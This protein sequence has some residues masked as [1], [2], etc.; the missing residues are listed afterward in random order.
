[1]QDLKMLIKINSLYVPCQL[2]SLLIFFKWKQ[3]SKMSSIKSYF[4]IWSKIRESCMTKSKLFK[5]IFHY[6]HRS[7]RILVNLTIMIRLK[8]N[9]RVWSLIYK[10]Y[11]PQKI[12]KK[13]KLSQSQKD[14]SWSARTILL[15]QN[16]F[17]LIH[18]IN[19][20]N[21]CDHR[22]GLANFKVTKT[23]P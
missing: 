7:Q 9:G 17:N 10:T 4:R 11:I 1:M 3:M 22:E 12:S 18:S 21:L 8:N 2:L 19:I 20:F 6:W 14:K 23:W 13:T 5:L 16:S 15:S